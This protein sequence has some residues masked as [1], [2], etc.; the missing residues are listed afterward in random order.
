MS[1]LSYKQLDAYT[2]ATLPDKMAVFQECKAQF[3]ALPVNPRK[4]RQ[5]LARLLRLLYHGDAFEEKQATELYFSIS[6]LFQSK[7]ELLRQLTY[8]AVKELLHTASNVM[9][10]TSSIMRDIQGAES[11]CKPNAL[12]AL[13]KVVDAST[14]TVTERTFKNAVVDRNPVVSS[15][16]LVALYSLLPIARDLVKRLANET[17]E[18]VSLS[19]QFPLSQFA[20][21]D[22]YGS[23]TT[24]L[25]ATSYMYQYHALGLL[26]QLRNHDRMALM[27]MIT[28]LL[29]VGV[30]KNLLSLVQLIRYINRLVED[31]V[32]L[33]GPLAPILLAFL[34]HKSDM[35]ELEACKALVGMQQHI[36]DD[37]FMAIVT[38]LQKLLSVP[39]T[40]TRFAAVRLIS[41]IAARYPEKIVVVSL[42]LEGLINDSNRSILT[43]AITTL[44][45]T[46]GAGTTVSESAGEGV[47]RLIAKMASMMEEIT[48][49]F[50]IVIIEAIENLAL[51][52]PSKHKR[53]VLFLTD[54]LRED[55]TLNLKSTIVD[56]LFDLIRFLP[57][58]AAKQLIL[59]NLCE[60]IEDCE[61]SELLVRILHLL[62][63]EGPATAN[64]SYY[65][66]HIYNRLVLENSIVRSLAVIALAKFAVV[67]GG[68]VAANIRILLGRCLNDVDDEVRDRAALSLQ[69]IDKKRSRLV[70]TDAKF[71]LGALE[72]R[73][74]HYLNDNANFSTKFDISEVPVISYEE[75]KSAAYSQKIRKLET[76]TVETGD[77]ENSA[78]VAPETSEAPQADSAASDLLKQQQYAQD[79]SAV[80]EFA[81]YGRL[82]K[83]SLTPV[84]LTDKEN[85]FVVTVTKHFFAESQKLVLQYDITNTL[86]HLVLQ[87]LSV[88]ALPDNELYTEDFI[89]SLGELKPEQTGTVYVSFSTPTLGDEELLAAFGNT[90]SYTNREVV[91]EEGNVDPSDEG[92]TDEYQI[93]DLEIVP[94]DFITPL[95]NSNFTALFDQLPYEE[96]SVVSVAG[97]KTVEAAVTKLTQKFNSLPLD[98]SDYVPSD[99]TSHT[100]KLLGKDLWGGKVG[101]SVRLALSGGKVVAKVQVKAETEGF[102]TVVANS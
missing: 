56:A 8:L 89:I 78:S 64:P 97:A 43:L 46:M 52:F 7:D 92:W 79:L 25:P 29:G 62:G 60:F 36:K 69:F 11:V 68:D 40:A 15:A 85:E 101:S 66:R 82:L 50:K 12:R 3:N 44:L 1:T 98:G 67:C 87:D 58:A 21:H 13:A 65:I 24:N 34:K 20:L 76:A 2:A 47:D 17:L 102:A 100:L 14:A 59:M 28:Q 26:Y 35:V 54:L 75:L 88:I 86:S 53:L 72:S 33:A 74:T 32:A 94:G 95:Y 22:Y 51:K 4:C 80:A 41:R 23:A 93:E 6:K 99:A 83:S 90:L 77:K 61:F 73:L 5:L 19:K 71:D 70:V 10:L 18:T 81:E 55:G 63:D 42:E 30:L 27:K 84:Y 57:D 45:R 38:T 31:D 16:A 49:D 48:E 91:D 9:M 37:T 96:S 39:R